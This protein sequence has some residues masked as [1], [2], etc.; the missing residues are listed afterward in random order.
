MRLT[1]TVVLVAVLAASQPATAQQQFPS[2]PVPWVQ[3]PFI[4]N[5]FMQ[6]DNISP[7]HC[8]TGIDIFTGGGAQVICPVQAGSDCKVINNPIGGTSVL[9]LARQRQQGKYAVF[10]ALHINPSAGVTQNTWLHPNDLL[11][12][13]TA[14]D[15]HL[16]A[17]IELVP[18]TMTGDSFLVHPQMYAFSQAHRWND[19]TTIPTIDATVVHPGLSGIPTIFEVRAHDQADANTSFFN[20]ISRIKLYV[21]NNLEDDIHLD[22]MRGR[23]GRYPF[24]PSDYYYCT[25]CYPSGTNNPNVLTYRLL[26]NTVIGDHVWR[27][28]VYDSKGNVKHGD[29]AHGLPNNA[30]PIVSI[31]GRIEDGEV[32]LAWELSGAEIEARQITSFSVWR[33]MAKNGAFDLVS[34]EPIAASAKR[35][36]YS[37]VADEPTVAGR[38]WYRLTAMG[39]EGRTF[40]AETSLAVPQFT[41]KVQGYPNPFNREAILKIALP[42]DDMGVVQVFDIHGRRVRTVYRGALSKG[43]SRIRW[44]GRDDAGEALP[45]GLYILR[46]SAEHVAGIPAERLVLCR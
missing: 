7:I 6:L 30:R 8:H 44:D 13:V 37:F 41:A 19:D 17:E 15:Q 26:W 18:G 40:L 9:L 34:S 33:G 2:D 39:M 11:G 23:D 29:P 36:S 43:I 31:G 16:H 38:A 35:A 5:Q 28:D 24:D 10:Q 20:G 42:R 1:R 14:T 25:T 46:T 27:L 21:D 12:L 22:E 45:N 3:G 4:T 32:F